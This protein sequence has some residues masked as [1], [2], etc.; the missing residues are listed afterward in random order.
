MS[1]YSKDFLLDAFL[2]RYYHLSEEKFAE[3]E[4]MA[5]KLYNQVGKDRFMA[6]NFLDEETLKE[7]K[8]EYCLDSL[9]VKR[10]IYIP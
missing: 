5:N 2:S 8:R 4:I 1:D 10:R 6:I 3:M 7:Y 9:M